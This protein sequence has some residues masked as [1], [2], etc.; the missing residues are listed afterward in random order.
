MDYDEFRNPGAAY[1]GVTLWMLND[2]LERD[3]IVRQ[4]RGFKAAGWGALIG[5]T[6]VGLRTKYLSDEWMD[7][8]GLIIQEAKKEGLKVWLQAGFMP[9]GIPD[10]APEWQHRVLVRRSQAHG[11]A[12]AP[13]QAALAEKDG[14]TYAAKPLDYTLDLLNPIAV[15]DYL[16]KAYE[17]PWWSRFQA[18]FGK[19]IETVW[20][21]EPHLRP[22]DLPWGEQLPGIFQA[23][24]GYAITD[25]LPALFAEVGEWRKVRHQYWRVVLDM[26]LAGY[27]KP[28]SEWCAAHGVKFGGHLMGEDTVNA[29]I[30]WTAACM[31][32]YEYMQLP[33]IDHLTMSLTWPS[34]L[35]FYLT[36]KQI[37]SAAHQL[38]Q[39][40]VLAEM[41]GVSSSR[42]SFA[43]RKRISDWMALLGIT[44]RCYHGSFY[45]MRGV[46]KRIYV[47]H[48]GYQQPWWPDNRLV[49][50]Y[51]ARV[52]YT[53][54]Q[55]QY[56]A[57]VLVLHP[58]ES[59]FAVYDPTFRKAPHDRINEPP[60]IRALTES[61]TTVSDSL[62]KVHR[63]FDYGDETLLARHGRVE[64]GDLVMGE[65][66]YRAI[67]L[68]S[69]YTIRKTTLDLLA[70][71][72]AAGGAVLSAGELPAL[73]DG[74]LDPALADLLAEVKS[75]ANTAEALGAEL[76]RL[77]PASVQVT[78]A[79][80]GAAPTVWVHERR[81][82]GQRAFY[83]INTSP[84]QTVDT[85]IAILGQGRLER[86][87]LESGQ[88]AVQAQHCVGERV[89][90]ELTFAPLG[91]HL[92]VLKEGV[93][94]ADVIVRQ[95]TVTRT[96]ALPAAFSVRRRDPNALTLDIC[97]FRKGDDPWSAPA[98]VL[99][100]Q[101]LLEHED[102][103][104]PVTLRFDFRAEQKPKALA[105]VVE[106]AADYDIT[107]NGQPVA[108]AGLPYYFDRAFNP[109]DITVHVVPGENVIELARV[110]E[111]PSKAQFMLQRLFHT[112]TGVELES[113]YLTGDFA[114]RCPVS[115]GPA[116]ERCVRIAPDLAL[117]AEP[118]TRTGDLAT[119]GCPFFAGRL[120]LEQTVNLPKPES[121]EQV[122]LTLPDPGAALAH[123]SVNGRPAG[124]VCWPPY[125]VEITD[126]VSDRPTELSIELVTG[127]RNLLGPHHREQGE[128][129]DTW[130]S[131]FSGHG[132]LSDGYGGRGDKG[133][134][135]TDDYFVL[136]FGLR[137][138]GVIEYVR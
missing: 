98:P 30:G 31:P 118:A 75:V 52:S 44:Y 42:I 83:M 122:F 101:D 134:N 4:L 11:D 67:V 48:I 53:L 66:R 84:D 100:V 7:M 108:Y 22:P 87:D 35:P 103:R 33:G 41:Y 38:G 129:D 47:P 73:V 68:P 59:G 54:R 130:A 110:F 20:V 46:R 2:K 15:A 131:A 74:A 126:L 25:H 135:W 58:V 97:R 109:V 14:W 91:S 16:V 72:M 88:T 50:D 13:G 29:Q 3:E 132:T 64:G 124:S 123:V 49:A 76:D 70:H 40:E 137:G 105:V 9:S 125:R 78:A 19:T 85:R 86:W 51:A 26:F 18:E 82:A 104:G 77:I 32:C 28:V 61:L 5:R 136:P 114:V 115:A 99:A 60:A 133:V 10:L 90:T 117:T 1:R 80:G 69:L 36:P 6:F 113:I 106:D 116:R 12:A 96:F 27:F 128:P 92:L 89:Q 17:I 95:P 21:D 56:Q 57:D 39:P 107:I 79:G 120:A 8:I 37:S 93:A 111:P 121:G 45:S 119:A 71:F 102:Y 62:L 23:R 81:V 34:E 94:A 55:G 127:L 138:K 65:M 24:W 43:E 112:H 63:G